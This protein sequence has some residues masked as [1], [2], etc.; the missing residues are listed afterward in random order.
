MSYVLFSG[1]V[2]PQKENAYELS[3]R[4]VLERLKVKLIDLE[5]VNC[6]GFFLEAI[7]HLSATVLASRDLSLAEELSCDLITLCNGC[8]GHLSRVRLELLK[9]RELLSVVNDILKEVNRCFKGK[10]RVRHLI[11]VLLEDVGIAKIKETI[12][13]PLSKIKV[14]PHYGCHV[15]KPS[16][17]IKFDNPEDPKSLEV[18]IDVTGAKPMDYVDEKLCCGAPVMA[19]DE[20]L[21]LKVAREKLRNIKK[22]GAEAIITICPFC[23]LQFDLNQP[24]I[25]EQ[26]S[27]EYHIPILHYTQLLGLA[28]GFTP[29]EV[30]LYENRV[31]ADKILS[32]LGL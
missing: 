31:P 13:K 26:Y 8:F 22:A 9:D 6:C 19:I 14:A 28:Q 4:K 16:D 3:A 7:D 24:S 10:L 25:E 2:I 27:E 18:L 17:E 21:S 29:D 11:Q 32:V 12:K 5:E 30:G 15:L 23:H 20:K 1:C